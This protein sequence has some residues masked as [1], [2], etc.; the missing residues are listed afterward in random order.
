MKKTIFLLL[1]LSLAITSCTF[2]GKQEDEKLMLPQPI[3]QWAISAEASDAY[4]GLLGEQRDD[5][6]PYAATGEPDVEECGDDQKAW[7]ISDDNDGLHW[8]QLT[9][10]ENIYVSSIRIR[11]TMGPGAVVKIEL[12]KEDDFVSVWEGTD[13][14]ED[15]PGYFERHFSS[16]INNKT[17]NM[18]EFK[19]DTV[20]ITLDTDTEGWN[21]IDAVNLIGYEKI[22]FILNNSIM[23]D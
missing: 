3:E 5:Q 20:K 9:Y 11:E 22:W 13:N 8:L 14:N 6:S 21:E 19:T 17:I 10:D 23:Y 18:T 2:F 7:V 12:L 16:D 4:G 1:V 15:C